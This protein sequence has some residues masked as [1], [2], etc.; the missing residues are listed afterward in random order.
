MRE[1]LRNAIDLNTIKFAEQWE[2][3]SRK[4]LHE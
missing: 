2:Q 1:K 3:A 4:L